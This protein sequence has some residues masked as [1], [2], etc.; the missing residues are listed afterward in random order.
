MAFDKEKIEQKAIFNFWFKIETLQSW[1]TL[2]VCFFV[3]YPSF[4]GTDMNPSN[5]SFFGYFIIL[6]IIMLMILPSLFHSFVAT[7]KHFIKSR[8]YRFKKNINKSLSIV[9]IYIVVGYF[10]LTRQVNTFSSSLIDPQADFLGRKFRFGASY[11]E[12]EN[13][14]Y[15]III[16]SIFYVV[17]SALY[18]Y[19]I[20]KSENP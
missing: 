12:G 19:R 15:T 4:S 11:S 5:I 1:L 10:S 20:Q 17:I 3:I 16:A 9:S 6:F 2:A 18:L 8:K 14:F 7:R 13:L